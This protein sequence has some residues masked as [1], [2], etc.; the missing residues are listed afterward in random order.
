MIL[1]YSS[2]IDKEYLVGGRFFGDSYS[3]NFCSFVGLALLDWY[4]RLMGCFYFLS[5]C[6]SFLEVT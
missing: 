1:F 4:S 2:A 6:M 3:I 5:S